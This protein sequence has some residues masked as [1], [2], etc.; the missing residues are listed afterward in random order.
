MFCPKCGNEL[1][2]DAQF[3]DKCGASIN[4]A[5]PAK[6]AAPKE[7]FKLPDTR[8]WISLAFATVFFVLTFIPFIDG[9]ASYS[10]LAMEAF[11]AHVLFGLSKIFLI[12]AIAIY[13][14]VL[15]VNLMDLGIPAKIKKF[16][17]LCMYA[18]FVFSQLFTFIG[19]CITKGVT[20]G[21]AWYI[22]LIFVG[23]AVTYELVPG[24]F[25]VDKK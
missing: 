24:L 21:A 16:V 5:E 18:M 7:A 6:K 19:C 12:M 15:A 22:I 3:C 13:F 4:G 9:G 10:L 20:M 23:V 25:K 8:G 17:P 1:K 2:D 11:R 14:C